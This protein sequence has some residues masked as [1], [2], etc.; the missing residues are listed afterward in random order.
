MKYFLLVILTFLFTC[1]H[2][3]SNI[4]NDYEVISDY[5]NILLEE[6][7]D[8]PIDS[9]YICDS[10]KYNS[11]FARYIKAN[12]TLEDSVPGEL[13]NNFVEINKS[14]FKFDNKF[15][16]KLPYRLITNNEISI[17]QEAD[18]NSKLFQNWVRAGG[19]KY[20][21]RVG[22]NDS[23]NEAIFYYSAYGG[24]LSGIGSIV[25]MEKRKNS[26]TIKKSIFLWIS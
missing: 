23:Q 20:F 10:T 22:Y 26:W 24:P 2:Y 5:I 4:S 8:L 18:I 14:R 1:N 21:S 13:F 9:V 6:G 16:L 25:Y 7:K 3:E 19:V 17:L 11:E 15:F 12:K